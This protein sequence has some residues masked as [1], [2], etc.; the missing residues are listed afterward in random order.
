MT[1]NY[2]EKSLFVRYLKDD[3]RD[4]IIKGIKAE[5]LHTEIQEE[6]DESC[7]DSFSYK[8]SIDGS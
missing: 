3:E 6:S 7:S 8:E 2:V 1:E 5:K 4:L